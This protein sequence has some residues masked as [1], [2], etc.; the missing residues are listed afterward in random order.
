MSEATPYTPV[1]LEAAAE[2]TDWFDLQP[3]RGE[4]LLTVTVSGTVTYYVD[5]S[6][7]GRTDVTKDYQSTA[8]FTA[9]IAKVFRGA[10][11]RYTRVRKTAGSG[12]VTVSLGKAENAN[13]SLR[14]VNAQSSHE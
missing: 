11:P 1:V 5:I 4:L 8:A 14:E 13:G 9:S 2:N 6:N 7:D 3:V 12:T 10:K